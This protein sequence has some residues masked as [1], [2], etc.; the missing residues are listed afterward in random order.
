MSNQISKLNYNHS[1]SQ[2]CPVRY[3]VA[4]VAIK[5]FDKETL[6]DLKVFHNDISQLLESLA[7]HIGTLSPHEIR[8]LIFSL[9][10]AKDAA[11]AK[12]LAMLEQSH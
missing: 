7:E 4:D 12:A 5:A 11:I 8:T 10:L 9:N 1:P 3:A 2:I 6:P